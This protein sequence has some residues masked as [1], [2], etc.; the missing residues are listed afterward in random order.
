MGEAGPYNG[1]YR[2][3][4]SDF[5]TSASRLRA[6]SRATD[7]LVRNLFRGASGHVDLPTEV[8]PLRAAARAFEGSGH[9]LK[10]LLV[11]LALSDAFR[12]GALEVNP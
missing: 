5:S 12:F 1:P 4:H 3:A 11:E 2:A 6:D 7:C 8:R 10:A 9:D